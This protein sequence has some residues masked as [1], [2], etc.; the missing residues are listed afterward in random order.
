SVR[1][2]TN[3]IGIKKALGA[4]SRV[5]LAEFLLESAFLCILGGIIGLLL[6]F[7][8]TVIL[9]TALQFPVYISTTNMALAIFI[10]IFVG[11]VAGY[12][13]ARQA[14]KMDPAVAI[15]EK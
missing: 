8:L 2:R 9:S 4:K 7:G 6:V 15:R 1:E 3:Q 13:P 5:I 11:I 14:A 12:I 10:C